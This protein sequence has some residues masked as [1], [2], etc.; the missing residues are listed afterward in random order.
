MHVLEHRDRRN[1]LQ[2]SRIREG[3]RTIEGQTDSALS[4]LHYD[5][6]MSLSELSRRVHFGLIAPGSKRQ[7]EVLSLIFITVFDLLN[8]VQHLQSGAELMID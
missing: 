1:R 2:A 6:R 4:T 7:S 3:F 8:Q 5:L